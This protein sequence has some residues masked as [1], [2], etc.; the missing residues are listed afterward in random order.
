MIEAI[1]YKIKLSLDFFEIFSHLTS[2]SIYLTNPLK[3]IFS[4]AYTLKDIDCN[5]FYNTIELLF[6]FSCVV[7]R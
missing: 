2:L 4:R 1:P 5:I 3:L 6:V 7:N